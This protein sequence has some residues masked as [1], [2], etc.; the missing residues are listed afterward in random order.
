MSENFTAEQLATIDREKDKWL[1][2]GR[3]TEPADRQQTEDAIREIYRCVG[4]DV[5]KFVWCDGP[6][7]CCLAASAW[8]V[9]G[10]AYKNGVPTAVDRDYMKDTIRKALSLQLQPFWSAVHAHL[11]HALAVGVPSATVRIDRDRFREGAARVNAAAQSSL[12]H[13]CFAVE[14]GYWISFYEA[15]TAFGVTYDPESYQQLKTWSQL[16]RSGGWWLPFASVC[17]LAERHRIIQFDQDGRLHS[18][19]GPALE[20]RD[21]VRVYSWHGVRIPESWIEEKN[22]LTAKIALTWENVEQRRCAAE[23]IGWNKILQELEPIVLD[24]DPDPMVGILLQVQL[25]DEDEPRRFLK[26]QCGTGRDFVLP[27]DNSCDTALEAQSWMYD[28]DP[29]VILGLEIRT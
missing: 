5:P 11:H 10:D 14:E 28:V 19:T 18:E 3:C 17:F 21:G 9:Y 15:A 20:C 25:P 23:I 12:S 29:E 26:V 24:T 27:V 16:A 22:K 2:L 4:R 7:S 13:A 8:D 6:L 1:G